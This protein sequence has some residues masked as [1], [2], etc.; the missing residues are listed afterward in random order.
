MSDLLMSPT[1]N[2]IVVNKTKTNNNSFFLLHP[3]CSY[4]KQNNKT[5]K[6]NSFIQPNCNFHL[7]YPLY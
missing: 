4:Y 7:R 3:Q 6:I 1:C 5:F 2:D